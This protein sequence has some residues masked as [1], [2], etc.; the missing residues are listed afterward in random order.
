MTDFNKMND[1]ERGNNNESN[2]WTVTADEMPVMEQMES[3]RQHVN[4]QADEYTEKFRSAEIF[5]KKTKV[6]A[7][8]I[9]AE[10]LASGKYDSLD[11]RQDENGQYV[12][13]TYIMKDGDNGHERALETT[14]P[15][16]PGEWI[17][18]NPKQQDGDYP[19]NYAIDGDKFQKRYEPTKD[20]EFIGPLVWLG[21]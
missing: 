6:G 16:V 12:I 7:V 14:R 3:P 19:N 4:L 20:L 15:V 18:T 5:A 11:V 13:D 9:T 2:P 8:E 1:Q 21:L 10:G 17:L